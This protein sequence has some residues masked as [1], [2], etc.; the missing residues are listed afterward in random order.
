MK[1]R[2]G[3]VLAGHLPRQD[4]CGGADV[5]RHR[6]DRYCDG[7]ADHCLRAVEGHGCSRSLPLPGHGG[8]DDIDL[9]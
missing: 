9:C 8:A 4:H 1:I 5:H 7:H 6:V 2:L 3:A